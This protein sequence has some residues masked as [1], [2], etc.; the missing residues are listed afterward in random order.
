MEKRTPEQMSKY[1]TSRWFALLTAIELIEQNCESLNKD[2]DELD[3]KPIA[4]KHYVNSLSKQ[5]EN[6]MEVEEINKQRLEK[7]VIM[8][9][10]M[11]GF[12]DHEV[13]TATT[14]HSAT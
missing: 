8:D 4:I 5:Y 14:H 7:T 1:E 10:I 12:S 3:L 11:R 6:D 2:F 9:T 13:E